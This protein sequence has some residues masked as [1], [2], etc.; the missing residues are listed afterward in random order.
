M[1]DSL[2]SIAVEKLN[3]ILQDEVALFASVT[4]DIKKLSSTFELI[5]AMLEDAESQRL[6]KNKE[7]TIWLEKIK[8]VAYDVDDIID[9]WT[10]SEALRSQATDEGDVSC[11]S[12]NNVRSF[13]SPVTCFNH[14]ML[15]HRIGS[16][17]REARGRLDDI[18]KDMNQ[19]GLSVSVGE[20]VRMDSQVRQNENRKRETSS[21]V[22]R[23]SIV[24]REDDKNKILDL[25][26]SESSQEVTEVP[27][28]ISIVG[29]GGLGKTSLAKLVYNDDK[30]K[31]GRFHKKMWVC[32]SENFDVKQ[33]TKLMIES[34]TGS[35]PDCESLDQ[36]QRRLY[37]F[38]HSKRFLLVLDDIWSEDR[39]MW[40]E[41]RLP[42]Q[43]G[44]V[45]SRIII[46]TRSENV[47]KAMG[48]TRTCKLKVLSD[49][50]CWSLFSGEALEHRSKTER[51]EL[52]EIG[53]KIVKKCQGV[54]L[55]A[56]T[57]GSAMQSRRTRSQWELV[58][59]S[60]IWNL[61]D[62]ME[63]I[64]PAL[65]LSYY[66]LPPALKQ[67]FAYCSIF[68]K[69]WE[70]KKDKIVK[71]W[72]A[73]GFIS[74]D[75]SKEMEEIGGLYFDDLLKRSLLQD[76]GMDDDGKIFKCKMHDLVHDLAQFVSGNDCSIM[77]ITQGAMLNLN[78]VH[79]SSL[80]FTGSAF[81]VTSIPSTFYKVHKLR[82]LLIFPESE[83]SI[84]LALR[85]LNMSEMEKARSCSVLHN[86]FHHLR[87]LRA[88]EIG[89][90]KISRLPGT[91]RQLKQLRY[92]DL[93]YSMIDELPEE[94]I[95]CIN[96]QSL[97]LNFCRFLKRLPRE[98]RKL[99]SLRHLELRR[100]PEL[101]YLPKGIGR[102]TSLQTLTEFI[103]GGNDGCELG[104]LKHLN[105]LRG[106][107]RITQLQKAMSSQDDAMQADLYKKAELH[108]LI[109][110]YEYGEV[111]GD[112]E[113][114]RAEVVLQGLQPHTNLKVLKIWR[115]R[116]SKF[117][118]WMGDPSFSNLISVE[119]SDCTE[120]E[121]LPPLWNLPTLRKLGVYGCP[122]LKERYKEGGD[123]RHKIAHI[124]DLVVV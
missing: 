106:S 122:L 16:R 95:D 50:E 43:A 41:L 28:V 114:R 96:L 84:Y 61:A 74:S 58:L 36:L 115:Y 45:G 3:T 30:L 77:K 83:L 110:S 62:V 2:I 91:V 53:R 34:A 100:T 39:R 33:I 13:L 25:L 48:S 104:E 66:D 82:T 9:E 70:I 102:L 31:E 107:L 60:E 123:D 80:T 22:D 4:N 65:L 7:V 6:K 20:R 81:Q 24:G 19:L 117:P 42:F 55:A 86:L 116:G 121:E 68:P 118:D 103:V 49:D 38:L 11:F 46:T 85:L 111:V 29:M 124:S 64:L 23:L 59:E 101:E 119:L 97:I 44:A 51:S 73:Q 40:D 113:K 35:A 75:T 56:K 92:L 5:Q 21:L 32:V 17:I 26:L 15:R 98:M 88:L 87:C 14:V 52:E 37:E 63:G 69:D 12:K 1:V 76:A 112:E 108:T 109:L 71:L 72:V 120:C 78:K 8:D 105:L 10:T 27:F 99:I 89:G 54:P 57:I 18:A 47:A 79:H 90:A 67:C 93:S 94:L